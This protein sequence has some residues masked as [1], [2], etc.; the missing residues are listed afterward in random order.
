[1]SLAI[2]HNSRPPNRYAL[3]ESQPEAL[4]P[5]P[6][7]PYSLE[8]APD[9]DVRLDSRRGSLLTDMLGVPQFVA[10]GW[11]YQQG[12]KEAMA[13]QARVAPLSDASKVKLQ[14]PLIIVPGWTT[15]PDKFD[16]LVGHLL[17]S[18]ENGERTVYLKDG[19]AFTDKAATQKTEIQPDDK[20]FVAI[21]D[22]VLS[23]PD[24]TAP[25][26]EKIIENAKKVVGERV[27]VLG[28]SM[29]GIAVRNMLDQYEEKLDQVAF[30]GSP[31][32]GTR[33]AKLAK[34]MVQRDIGWAMKMANIGPAHLPAMSWMQPWDGSPDSNP[35]LHRLNTHVER[36]RS[37]TR[38]FASFGSDGLATVD[39]KLGQTE[40]GDGLVGSSSLK[41]P[42]VPTTVLSGRGNKQHGNIVHDTETFEA[43]ADYYDWQRLT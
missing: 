10:S 25:Q 21:F 11:L 2:Q 33:F 4:P 16:H 15:Q 39:G 24:R 38:E 23:A 9:D 34:Y 13:E 36:Q 29:G 19:H 27:D 12:A 26:L 43:L 32:R 6:N 14:D 8:A 1:M 40:G 31:H 28:Y 35:N 17:S 3:W 20:V 41:I 22:H 37:Q 18:G 7:C 5:D 42:G 30:L